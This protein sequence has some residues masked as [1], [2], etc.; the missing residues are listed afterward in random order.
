MK[1]LKFIE[2]L[3]ENH[4]ADLDELNDVLIDLKD[5]MVRDLVKEIYGYNYYPQIF[6]NGK[7]LGGLKFLRDANHKNK[8]FDY[9]KLPLNN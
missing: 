8:I 2:L 5:E 1:I 7:F 9:V 3:T 6:F 4:Q